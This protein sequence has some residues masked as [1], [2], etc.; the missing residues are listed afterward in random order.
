MKE[1]FD[2]IDVDYK[3]VKSPLPSYGVLRTQSVK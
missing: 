2:G 3:D 1:K